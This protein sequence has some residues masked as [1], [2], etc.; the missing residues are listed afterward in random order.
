[1]KINWTHHHDFSTHFGV[2][3][4]LPDD[5]LDYNSDKSDK[6]E[7]SAKNEIGD[8]ITGRDLGVFAMTQFKMPD[9]RAKQKKQQL[10]VK[11]YSVDTLDYFMWLSVNNNDIWTSTTKEPPENNIFVTYIAPP[12]QQPHSIQSTS[13]FGLVT[14]NQSIIINK[15]SEPQQ[16]I[17]WIIPLFILNLIMIFQ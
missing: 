5:E 8:V 14:V 1:M 16:A 13:D 4:L 9:E 11:T 3:P 7:S 12:K 15:E 17:I 10:I 2:K 6:S